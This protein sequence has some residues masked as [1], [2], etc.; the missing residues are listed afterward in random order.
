MKATIE[1]RPSLYRRLLK[2]PTS[3]SSRAQI[4]LRSGASVSL[5]VRS[6]DLG[7][8]MERL[9]SLVLDEAYNLQDQEVSALAGAQL[10]SPNSQTIYA[11]TAPVIDAHPNCHVLSGMRRLGLQKQPDLYYAEFRAEEGPPRDDPET[12]RLANPSYGL[13]AKHRDLQRL[14]AKAKTLAAQALFDAD[15][16]GLGQWPPDEAD[17]QPP[18]PLDGWDAMSIGDDDVPQLVGPTVIALDRSPDRQVWALCAA[19]RTVDGRIHLELGFNQAASNAA[20]VDYVTD[21]VMAWDPAAIVMD[22]RSPAA[23]LR[24][25]LAELGIEATL[26][27]AADLAR[28]FGGFL[29]ACVEGG[30]SHTGQ[31]IL[32]DA[33]SA[34]TKRDL[35][36]GGFAWDKRVPGS[37]IAQLCAATLAHW[38]LLES[39][40]PPTTMP[41]PPV[42]GSERSRSREDDEFDRAL[43][44]S[45]D[46][47]RAPF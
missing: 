8:G 30:L 3:S 4:E 33:V 17:V 19:Q 20:V 32:A 16:L 29:D 26:T 9:D 11:S 38:G 24:P 12:W 36:G 2:P 31:Q 6:G 42:L 25:Q 21:V 13:L 27:N 34:A 41:A 14:C 37:S 35:P 23:V 22:Q 44:A 1:A 45:Q 7:R 5:G 47:F 28:A 18:I 15:Y 40:S 46:I 10:S 43:G 39:G